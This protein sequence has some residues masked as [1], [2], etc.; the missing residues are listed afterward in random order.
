MSLSS[1]AAITPQNTTPMMLTNQMPF[2]PERPGQVRARV[3]QHE[4]ADARPR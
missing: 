3:A 1:V 4:H 2:T